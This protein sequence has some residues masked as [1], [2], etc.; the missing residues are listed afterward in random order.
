MVS[1]T[2]SVPVPSPFKILNPAAFDGVG[3]VTPNAGGRSVAEKA[4][5]YRP[6]SVARVHPRGPSSFDAASVPERLRPA[7]ATR[8][9][10]R[11]MRI[12][13]HKNR[14]PVLGY[15]FCALVP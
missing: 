8:P 9:A 15:V 11:A 5:R 10:A 2:M 3:C 6:F 7:M 14:G 4:N 12:V 1:V 13:R